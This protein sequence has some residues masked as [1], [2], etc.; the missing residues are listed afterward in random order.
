MEKKQV[1]A[2]NIKVEHILIVL[3]SFKLGDYVDVTVIPGEDAQRDTIRISPSNFT[4]ALLP[5]S[6][7]NQLKDW[8][9][10]KR[11]NDFI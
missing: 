11:I 10:L 4:P 6:T 3:K 7:T 2:H 8:F 9:D 5:S 1:V